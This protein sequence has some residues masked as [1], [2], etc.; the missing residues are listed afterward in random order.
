[1][2]EVWLA[3]HVTLKTELAV[4]FLSASLTGDMERATV[5]EVPFEARDLS[6]PERARAHRRRPRRGIHD[7]IPYLVMEYIPGRT[8]FAEVRQKGRSIRC[9]SRAS[10]I[11][12]GTRS[13]WRTT[14][15][16]C[17]AT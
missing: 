15:A 5:L 2:A 9:A 6:P 16:S 10:L 11:R 3:V 8:L 4:K 7:D 12:S 13:P 14:W 17:T 1:M